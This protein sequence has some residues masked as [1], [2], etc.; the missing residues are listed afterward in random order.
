MNASEFFVAFAARRRP[1]GDRLLRPSVGVEGR[2]LRDV[3]ESNEPLE[4]DVETIRGEIE[5]NLWMLEPEAF[6]F[7]LPAFL[8]AA[9]HY[10]T[11]LSVFASEL[12]GAL[13]EPSRDDVVQSFDRDVQIPASID[14]RRSSPLRAQQLEWF[15]SGVPTAIFR[16]RVDNLN[17]VEGEAVLA[18]FVAFANLH[19][20]DFPFGELQIAVDRHWGRYGRHSVDHGLGGH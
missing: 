8:H 1:L 18:F 11:T 15:D 14:I 7:F 17:R 20:A 9:L 13:T 6:Q 4:L 10:Y 12:V 2:R 5:G 16:E 19:S 3:L